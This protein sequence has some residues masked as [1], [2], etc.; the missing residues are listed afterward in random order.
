MG[1][2]GLVGKEGD[3]GGEVEVLQGETDRKGR[4]KRRMRGEAGEV[5]VHFR[6]KGGEGRMGS[7]L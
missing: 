2:K 5:R 6:A 7:Q 1:V 4:S 3:D